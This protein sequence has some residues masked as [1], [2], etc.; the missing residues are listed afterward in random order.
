MCKN[1]AGLEMFSSVNWAPDNLILSFTHPNCGIYG[2]PQQ[3]SSK[4]SLK[5]RKGHIFY[6]NSKILI[7]VFR[8]MPWLQRI[9][10]WHTYRLQQRWG[11]EK[12]QRNLRIDSCKGCVKTN[13]QSALRVDQKK[14]HTLAPSTCCSR[15]IS[16]VYFGY[17]FFSEIHLPSFELPK[18]NWNKTKQKKQPTHN[19]KTADV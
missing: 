18:V 12:K 4:E 11:G 8:L 9:L 1:V 14:K 17:Y 5:F 6:A 7:W 16:C 10:L 19:H 2:K 3:I 15:E 13:K